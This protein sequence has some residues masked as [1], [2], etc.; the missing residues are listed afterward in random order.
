VKQLFRFFVCIYQSLISFQHVFSKYVLATGCN[1]GCQ[2]GGV[3][4]INVCVC[5]AGY[6]GTLCETR[7]KL[8]LRPQTKCKDLINI[9]NCQPTNPC[10]NGGKC[11]SIG[12]SF[13][14]DCTS[15]GYSGVLCTEPIV[16]NPCLSAPCQNGGQCSWN[17]ATMSCACI[18]GYTGVFCQVA[19]SKSR[20]WNIFLLR[21]SQS[22]I[23]FSS[24]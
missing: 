23:S 18:N 24:M 13:T 22:C 20:R 8:F 2:N 15:T 21:L 3:C 19:P 14:C 1:P 6:I 17:G 9:D 10:S 7:G 16:T 5:P 11:T 12:A 4:N